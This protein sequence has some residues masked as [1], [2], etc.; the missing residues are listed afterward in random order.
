MSQSLY[1]NPYQTPVA[2]APVDVRVAFLRKVGGLT[3]GG[4]VISA[5]TAVMSTMAVVEIE[6]LQGRWV[7][8]GVMLGAIFASQW[9]GGSLVNANDKSTQI[10]GFVLGT[11]LQG[12]AMGYLLLTAVTL[13]SQLYANPFVFLIQAMSLVGLTVL[14]MVLY[15]MT[16]PKQLSMI[17]SVMATLSLPLLGLMVLSFIF[18]MGGIVGILIN[19]VFVALSAGGL[20]YNLNQVMHQMS[21]DRVVPAAYHVTLGV[22]TLFWNVLTL[23]MRLQ[24]RR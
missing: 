9:V 4:L 17:G 13:S 2:N 5:I 1:G 22:L 15:L 3:F 14:G 16:G 12:V 10:A 7:S 19:I 20:L 8:L 24:D 21:T 11:G 23:L 6:A 18:P